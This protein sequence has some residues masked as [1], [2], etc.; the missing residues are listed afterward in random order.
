MFLIFIHVDM[1]R[2]IIHEEVRKSRSE[3]EVEI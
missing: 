2:E 1:E 3:H